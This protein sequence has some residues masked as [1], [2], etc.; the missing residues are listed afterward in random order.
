MSEPMVRQIVLASRP[1]GPPT[2]E[3]FRLEEVPR[4][5]MPPAGLLLR[6]LYLSVT[7][8]EILC[9]A[10]RHWRGHVGR[11]RLRGDR[12]RSSELR[13]R[14]HHSGVDWL[15][16]PCGMG[17]RSRPLISGSHNPPFLR[18]HKIEE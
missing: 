6:V 15:A 13:C 16:H 1:K 14:R 10:R 2:P 8:S 17:L 18:I 3:N 11:E 4:P 5:A 7:R 9:E 12:V